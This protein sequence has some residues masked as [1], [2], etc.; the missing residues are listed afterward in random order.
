MNYIRAKWMHSQLHEPVVLLSE[1]DQDRWEIRKVEIYAD[2]RLDYADHQRSSSH[3]RLSSEPIPSL[4]E[5]GADKQF[6]PSEISAAE[7]EA[8][9]NRA[10][11]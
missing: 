9:W 2:G 3:T 11:A 1:L 7:F 6:E 10:I 4:A 5:I 8:A